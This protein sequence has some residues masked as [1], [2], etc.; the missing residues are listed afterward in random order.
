MEEKLIG[1]SRF[2]RYYV[3]PDGVIVIRDVNGEARTTRGSLNDKTGYM[4][5]SYRQ[6][7]KAF[8]SETVHKLVA[9]ALVE[10]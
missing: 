1:E 8:R 10:S 4:M 7:N 5:M 2:L 9:V 6:Q 3:R